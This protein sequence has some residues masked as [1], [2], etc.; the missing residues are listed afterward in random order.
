MEFSVVIPAYKE[1]DIN[2]VLKSVLGQDISPTMKLNKIF[3]ITS[4]YK[5]FSFLGD[6]KIV[7]IEEK[8]RGGK[9]A[10]INSALKKVDSEIIVLQSGDVLLD[11]NAIKELLMPFED[12]SVGMTTSRPIPMNDKSKFMGFVIHTLWFFHHLISLQRPKAGEVIAFRKLIKVIPKKLVADES[13][14]EF[15]IRENGLKITYVPDAIVFNKGPEN[16]KHFLKQRKRVFIGHLHIRK[17]YGYTVS[18][19]SFHN[20]LKALFEYFNIKSVD[21]LKEISWIVAASLLE[22]AARFSA[23]LDFYILNNLPY[24]WEKIKT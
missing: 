14:L 15:F 7:F 20:M 2:K 19:M 10:A 8:N 22:L 5:N 4:G 3:L 11:K 13:Y 9:A 23:L 1:K 17:Q 12:S 16:V 24:K 6:K 18:T 21:N